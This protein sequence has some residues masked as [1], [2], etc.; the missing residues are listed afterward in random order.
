MACPCE[1]LSIRSCPPYANAEDVATLLSSICADC[2]A[3]VPALTDS[4]DFCQD[5]FGGAKDDCCELQVIFEGSRVWFSTDCS[6]WYQAGCDVCYFEVVSTSPQNTWCSL[7]QAGGVDTDCCTPM[8]FKE[9]D[10]DD[11]WLTHDCVTFVNLTTA[12][13]IVQQTDVQ[14]FSGSVAITPTASYLDDPQSANVVMT[15]EFPALVIVHTVFSIKG[16]SS[17]SCYIHTLVKNITDAT[18]FS[19]DSVQT[20]TVTN[21]VQFSQSQRHF[22]YLPAGTYTFQLQYVCGAS[23]GNP[24]E[25]FST[26]FV[27]TVYDIR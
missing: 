5:G 16:D 1:T 3:T 9:T 21:G 20:A 17:T 26:M 11:I 4:A 22:Q 15:L 2:V 14:T 25:K 12:T 10:T 23:C 6:N 27:H 7:A 19:R 13:P 8:F 18:N 24:L